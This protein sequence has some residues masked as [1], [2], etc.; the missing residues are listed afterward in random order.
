MLYFDRF[1]WWLLLIRGND[2][3]T[4]SSQAYWASLAPHLTKKCTTTATT[5]DSDNIEPNINIGN[6]DHQENAVALAL[7]QPNRN[8]VSGCEALPISQ[9]LTSEDSQ[10]VLQPPTIDII[11][12]IDLPNQEITPEKKMQLIRSPPPEADF[13]FPPKQYKDSSEKGGVKLRYCSRD[14]FEK[15]NTLCH[16]QCTDG[17]FCLFPMPAHHGQKAR[18]LITTPYRNWKDARSYFAKHINHEYHRDS[19]T[20][21]DDFMKMMT[22]P[23]LI[24]QNRLSQEAEKQIEKNRIFLTA[25][26][27]CTELC[28]RQGIG[29]RGHRHDAE[30]E[31]LNQGNFKA[32]LKLRVDASDKELGDHLETCDCNATYIS[33]TS[34]NE[35]LQCIQK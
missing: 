20:K 13:S 4:D 31:A 35:L 23:S 25:I 6:A 14:W 26:I 33:K 34:Q 7:H 1:V 19:K 24:I 8:R 32:L 11:T 30:S 29:L 15:Y 3:N 21:M 5:T 9:S 18:Y 12:V 2:L 10:E 22:N 27:K 16:L 17:I 28:G